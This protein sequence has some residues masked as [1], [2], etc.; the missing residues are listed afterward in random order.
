MSIDSPLHAF[1]Q[2]AGAELGQY[3]GVNLPAQFT[4]FAAEYRTARQS[5]TL[6]DTNFR[7]V[8][9]LTGPDRSRYLNAVLTSNVRDLRAAQGTIGL[10]LNAQGHILAELE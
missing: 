8:F 1:H 4:D 7:T 5:A 3:F 2:S 6:V 10:L 9:S